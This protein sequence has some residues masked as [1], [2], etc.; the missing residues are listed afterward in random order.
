SGS[1]NMTILTMPVG[2]YA[3]EAIVAGAVTDSTGGVLPGVA[4]K[5]ENEASGNT[6]QAV[7]DA[8]GAC[9][10]PVRVGVYKITAE[11]SGFRTVTREGVELLVGQTAAINLQ[12]TPSGV[13]ETVT[14][15]GQAPL[16]ETTTSSLGGNIDPRQ[17]SELP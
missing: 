4:V 10:I 16:V 2:G 17:V 3:Q 13:A 5:A 8:R 11:L 9:Q 7:T 12:L 6:F 14:V 1:S 15:T